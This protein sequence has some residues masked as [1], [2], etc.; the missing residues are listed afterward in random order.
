MGSPIGGTIPPNYQRVI[1]MLVKRDVLGE[2]T[3]KDAKHIH[4]KILAALYSEESKSPSIQRM[5]KM[6]ET[7]L[8]SSKIKI[9]R[10][11]IKDNEYQN[12]FS[13]RNIH[14]NF[15][16]EIRF[17]QF[18]PHHLIQVSNKLETW[19]KM[20]LGEVNVHT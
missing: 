7:S 8:H 2:T 9:W 14:S 18:E 6:F 10:D 5:A 4:K 13:Q 15:F 17:Q 1:D 12:P 20:I 16:K 11:F 3:S 19:T